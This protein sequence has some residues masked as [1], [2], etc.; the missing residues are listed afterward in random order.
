MRA[1]RKEHAAACGRNMYGSSAKCGRAGRLSKTCAGCSLTAW[2]ECCRTFPV[3]GMLRSGKCCPLPPVAPRTIGKG[4]SLLPTPTVISLAK[5]GFS[6]RSKEF[7]ETATN[8]HVYLIGLE[9]A[10]TGRQSLPH[11]RHLV[12]PSFAEWMMGVPEG[13]TK[14]QGP[15]LVSPACQTA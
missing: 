2:K 15:T 6:L 12:D 4:C 1:S 13:W 5:S 10:L 7:W 3:S 11:G 8:L 14:A 9:Y